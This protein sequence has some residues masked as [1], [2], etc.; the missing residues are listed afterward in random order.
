MK[1]NIMLFVQI[2]TRLSGVASTGRKVN[3]I[4][5]DIREQKRCPGSKTPMPLVWAPTIVSDWSM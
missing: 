1:V 2:L 5:Y 3:K 4:Y